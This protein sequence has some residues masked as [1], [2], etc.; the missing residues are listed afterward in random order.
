MRSVRRIYY[1]LVRRM[2]NI[3]IPV[4][5]GEFQLVDRKVVE[6]LCRCDDYYPYV[7]GMIAACG[8]RST[9]VPYTWKARRRG[10][11]SNRLY[12]LVDQGLNGLISFSNV[13]LRLCMFVGFLVSMLS[14]LYGLVALVLNLVYY[15]ELAPPGVPTLIVALFFFFGFQLLLF[16]L[17]G[18]YISAIH[19][20]VRKRPL[21]VERERI[22]FDP[23]TKPAAAP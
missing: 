19:S 10:L 12:D 11:S 16:G 2:A 14:F 5:V 6:A 22:N 20:Q 21:V 7:R 1:R 23:P 9:G 3:D 17:L 13:P 8:F 18:E 15:R 4:D